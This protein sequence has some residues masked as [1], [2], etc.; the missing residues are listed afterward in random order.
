MSWHAADGA[1]KKHNKITMLID[2]PLAPELSS[3]M[4][5]SAYFYLNIVHEKSACRITM[6]PSYAGGFYYI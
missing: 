1:G 5:C 6:V 4:V 2:F 3:T